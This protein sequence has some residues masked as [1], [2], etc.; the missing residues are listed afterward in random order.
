[1]LKR[2]YA[3]QGIPSIPRTKPILGVIPEI[4]KEAERRIADKENAPHILIEMMDKHMPEMERQVDKGHVPAF[5]VQVASTSLIMIQDPE[6]VR[7][8]MVS[9]N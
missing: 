1:L 9:K 5:I 3:A 8:A 7:D 2:R 4:A 6:M